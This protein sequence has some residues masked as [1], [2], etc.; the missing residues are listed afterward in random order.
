MTPIKIAL[1]DDHQ[2]LRIA[3]VNLI[4]NFGDFKVIIEASN[5]KELIKSIKSNSL[6]DI[7][8]LDLNMPELDGYDTSKWLNSNY[9]DIKIVMLTMYDAEAALI[10]LLRSGIRGFLRKDI[11]P[12]ELKQALIHVNEIGYYY[13]N[14]SINR[15]ATIFRLN[16]ED[17]F[18]KT[19]LSEEEVTFLQQTATDQTYKEISITLGITLR[20]VDHMRDQLFE[21]LEVKSRVGLALFA[22][23][24][25][26]VHI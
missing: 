9:P 26:L 22:I 3:L 12:T 11:H 23:K 17:I 6:P 18:N 8:I 15:L 16:K 21:K 13:T 7:I 19:I 4:N 5:G 14:S 25:G 20:N 24:N 10:R 2:L 1:V